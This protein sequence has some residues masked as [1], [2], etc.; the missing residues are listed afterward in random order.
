MLE[1]PRAPSLEVEVG[2]GPTHSLSG[3][4]VVIKGKL[5]TFI[6]AHGFHQ[7]IELSSP[8]DIYSSHLRLQVFLQTLDHWLHLSGVVVIIGMKCDQVAII[9]SRQKFC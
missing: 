3:L 5:S 2:R 8:T 1:I 9:F 7:G 6:M 4:S